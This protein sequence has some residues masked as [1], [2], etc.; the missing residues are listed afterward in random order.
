MV[1]PERNLEA[2][3]DDLTD[4]EI[5]ELR[6]IEKD[7]VNRTM[8]RFDAIQL[9]PR[10]KSIDDISE[11]EHFLSRLRKFGLIDHE[12]AEGIWIA[13]DIRLILRRIDNPPLPGYWSETIKWFRSKLW[14]VPIIAVV[15]LVPIIV[16]W[17]Q[18]IQFVLTLL[19]R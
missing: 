13:G 14:S 9:N 2:F 7:Y 6:R 19:P 5:E 17:V 16:G 3:V 11:K 18:A 15:V 1:L 12:E 4:R 10:T 8:S